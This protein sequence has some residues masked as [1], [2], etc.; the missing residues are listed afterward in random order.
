MNYVL[1]DV[2]SDNFV[3]FIQIVI[4]NKVT[5][6]LWKLLVIKTNNHTRQ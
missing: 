1:K 5:L 6:L 2:K 3:D 4:S